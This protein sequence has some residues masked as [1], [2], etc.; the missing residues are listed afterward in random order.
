MTEERKS[1][2]H[3]ASDDGGRAQRSLRR[4]ENLL[5]ACHEGECSAEACTRVLQALLTTCDR[6]LVV[7]TLIALKRQ[8]VVLEALPEDQVQQIAGLCTAVCHLGS[9]AAARLAAVVQAAGVSHRPGGTGP[10]GPQSS[11]EATLHSTADADVP[12]PHPETTSPAASSALIVSA[13]STATAPSAT[14]ALDP[15]PATTFGPAPS[16][17]SGPMPPSATTADVAASTAP[18]RDGAQPGSGPGIAA[19]PPS[20]AVRNDGMA[21]GLSDLI[22]RITGTIPEPACRSSRARAAYNLVQR[23]AKPRGRLFALLLQL[24]TS[25]QDAELTR[26]AWRLLLSSGLVKGDTDV[27]YLFQV[28]DPMQMG[29]VAMLCASDALKLATAVL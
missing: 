24:S 12:Q 16:D 11:A 4:I 26:D 9:G 23:V 5:A 20:S 15:T 8:N 29:Q 22:A 27:L 28:W 3:K 19:L 10:A 6:D 13:T 18:S 7:Q 2:K 14:S 1:K 25:C 17:P 21:A